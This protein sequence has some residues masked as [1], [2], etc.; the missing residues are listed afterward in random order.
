MKS[1]A[2]PVSFFILII[3]TFPQYLLA[4]TC[5]PIKMDTCLNLKVNSA[6]ASFL[7][8]ILNLR[9]TCVVNFVDIESG[10]KWPSARLAACPNE[11][12]Q[13]YMHVKYICASNI[14]HD[15]LT[16]MDADFCQQ[17]LMLRSAMRA[18]LSKIKQGS[19]MSMLEKYGLKLVAPSDDFLWKY[20]AEPAYVVKIRVMGDMCGSEMCK[21]PL[22][23]R[24]DSIVEINDYREP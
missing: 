12:A 9:Y 7:A 17:T 21:D 3:C 19:K 10:K 2:S 20:S 8:S 15:S 22:R 18:K 13:G 16:I 5:A 6:Q 1:I 11:G 14:G 24:F 4:Y 23:Q